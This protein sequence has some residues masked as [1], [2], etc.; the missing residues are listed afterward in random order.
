MD[1]KSSDVPAKVNFRSALK[2]IGR[3][4]KLAWRL[5]KLQVGLYSL[6]AILEITG[7]IISTYAGA[8]L[9]GLLFTAIQNQHQ[10]GAVWMWLAVTIAGQLSVNLGFW[11]M[12]YSKRILYIERPRIVESY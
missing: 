12:S 8:R 7:T 4:L 9:V 6:G 1:S 11:L 5:E 2:V 3:T 10:R